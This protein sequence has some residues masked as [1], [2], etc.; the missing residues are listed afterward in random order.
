MSLQRNFHRMKNLRPIALLL[1]LA[2]TIAGEAAVIIY[3]NDFS[4]GSNSLDDFTVGELGIAEV[5]VENGQLRINPGKN[6]LNRGFVALNAPHVNSAYNAVLTS[7]TGMI[8]WAFNISNL[9][10]A[11]N[12]VVGFH[13]FSTSDPSNSSGYGYSFLGGGLVGDRMRFS[14]S[15]LTNS[16]F[17]SIFEPMIDTTNGLSTLPQIGAFR[18]TF[19]PIAG[20]WN[21]YFEQSTSVIDPLTVDTLIGTSINTG[22]AHENLPFVIFNSH[23]SGSAF[24]D[25]FTITVTPEPS[26]VVLIAIGFL[27]TLLRRRHIRPPYHTPDTCAGNTLSASS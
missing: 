8:T 4:D 21:L 10:G 6:Y 13:L 16:P 26:G 19:E 1:V 9:D 12:N 27:F 15:A 23:T 25:N 17:G 3:H 7:N 20:E 18:L 2:T 11:S 22:F 5:L 14:R 24:I